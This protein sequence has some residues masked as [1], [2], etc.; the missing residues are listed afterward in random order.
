MPQEYPNVVRSANT[1]YPKEN[2]P[3]GADAP[4]NLI[5]FYGADSS[6]N[7]PSEP[8]QSHDGYCGNSLSNKLCCDDGV[9]TGQHQEELR[10]NCQICMLPNLLCGS[11]SSKL[12]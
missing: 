5:A 8:A 9:G 3:S 12:T 1:G 7:A 2:I 6:S 4:K 10:A 11:A